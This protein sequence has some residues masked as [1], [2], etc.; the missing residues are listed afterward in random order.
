M[1]I[2]NIFVNFDLRFY[3]LIIIKIGLFNNFKF[4]AKRVIFEV[5]INFR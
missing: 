4:G 5:L 2:R 1:R 3:I